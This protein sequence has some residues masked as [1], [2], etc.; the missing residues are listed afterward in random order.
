[1]QSHEGPLRS[2]QNHNRYFAAS[3]ILLVSNVLVGSKKN[4]EPGSLRFGQQ[5]A[6][7]KRVPSSLSSSCD[8][9]ARKEPGNAARVP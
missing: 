6:V 7:G 9:M 4:L 2:A 3:K 8:N 1:M 5:V